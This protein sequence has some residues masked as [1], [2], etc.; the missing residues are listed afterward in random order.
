MSFSNFLLKTL[1][2]KNLG[3]K[4]PSLKFGV[5]GFLVENFMVQYFMVE[6]FRV[7]KSVVEKSGLEMSCN[8]YQLR[9][10]SQCYR[11]CY[12]LSH[13]LKTE[14]FFL[15]R[16]TPARTHSISGLKSRVLKLTFLA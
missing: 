1:W 13:I 2:L 6:K 9:Y 14:F 4:S 8:F 7:E 3:L 15:G 11:Q 10:T 16:F 12:S 5:L